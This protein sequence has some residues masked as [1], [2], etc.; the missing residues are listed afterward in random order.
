MLLNA[1]NNAQVNADLITG[2]RAP[3]RT[4]ADVNH[5]VTL[6]QG[7]RNLSDQELEVFEALMGKV[8][9]DVDPDTPILERVKKEILELEADE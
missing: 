2:V 9:G 4:K 7:M 6:D 8:M 1:L 3:A 5:Q